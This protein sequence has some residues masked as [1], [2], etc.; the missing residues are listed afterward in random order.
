M[1]VKEDHKQDDAMKP[2]VLSVEDAA[3]WL[4]ISPRTLWTMTR[5]GEIQHLRIGRRVLYPLEGLRAYISAHMTGG[6]K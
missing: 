5:E 1:A 6:G 2:A 4:A 3:K